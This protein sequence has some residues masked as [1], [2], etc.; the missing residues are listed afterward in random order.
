LDLDGLH[1]SRGYIQNWLAGAEISDKSA[2][3][4]FSA[5]N[6]ILEAGKAA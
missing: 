6:K 1:E 2:Q 3:K 5:A 4:I